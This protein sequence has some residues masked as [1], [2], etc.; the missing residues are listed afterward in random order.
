MSFIRDAGHC[1]A[2]YRDD[3]YKKLPC[4]PTIKRIQMYSDSLARYGNSPFLYPLY[5]LGELPQ[6]FARFGGRFRS[7]YFRLFLASLSAIYGGTYMLQ[8]GVD[9]IVYDEEGHVAGVKSDGEVAKVRF[10]LEMH[11]GGSFHVFCRRALSLVTRRTSRI[12]SR[13][14]GKSSAASASWTTPS[15]T[16]RTP[17]HPRS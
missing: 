10:C 9:E 1:L 4:G 13:R 11:F 17:R 16:P 2:F 3:D 14:L 15:P 7:S 6:A 12:T 5:G 8:K